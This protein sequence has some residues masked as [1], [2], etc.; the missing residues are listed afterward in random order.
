MDKI[1]KVVNMREYFS[2]N[3]QRF[4][5]RY[6][7]D[8]NPNSD[9]YPM[10][11][12]EAYEL[13]YLLS[14]DICFLVEGVIYPVFPGDIV[15][16]NVSESHKVSFYSKTD[17]ERMSI[18]FSKSLFSNIPELEK[19]LIPFTSR[20]LGRQNILHETDFKDDYWKKCIENMLQK[21]RDHYSQVLSNLFPLMNEIYIAFDAK[22]KNQPQPSGP[23]NLSQKIVDYINEHFTEDISVDSVAQIFFISKTYLQTLVKQTT[24][25][26]VWEFIT[27]KRLLLARKKIM[28]GEKPI[29]V[30]EQCGFNDYTTFFRTYKKKFGSSPKHT[31]NNTKS[32]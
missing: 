8:T 31:E 29:K 6:L 11:A 13:F 16:F 21:S 1:G 19:Y 17:Y 9:N 7:K 2:L 22:L 18:H 10:H 12:H 23:P 5:I 3:S 24:G 20:K 27:T 14:G 28:E 25:S 32:L 26:T 15:L 4:Y 30:F